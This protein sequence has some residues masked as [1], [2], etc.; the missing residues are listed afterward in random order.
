LSVGFSDLLA[1]SVTVK[2]RNATAAVI[3]SIH[4][5]LK[6]MESKL[7]HEQND[8]MKKLCCSRSLAAHLLLSAAPSTQQLQELTS[9]SV[10]TSQPNATDL[11]KSPSDPVIDW[12]HILFFHLLSSKDNNVQ[13]MFLV[14]KPRSITESVWAPI[15]D[16]SNDGVTSL[17]IDCYYYDNNEIFRNAEQA[18]L[19]H[20]QVS[21]C[22]HHC[23]S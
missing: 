19:T 10:A 8:G 2:S 21:Y 4:N 3:S 6:Q 13:R 9:V 17:P 23:Y 16:D 5:G 22:H 15:S 14:L 20:E 18:V 12:L 11:S 1:A 7:N